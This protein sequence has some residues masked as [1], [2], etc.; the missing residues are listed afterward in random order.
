MGLDFAGNVGALQYSSG[1]A[2]DYGIPADWDNDPYDDY[3][4]AV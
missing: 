2:N 4:I 1:G 3:I